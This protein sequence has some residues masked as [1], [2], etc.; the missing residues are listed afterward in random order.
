MRAKAVSR[1]AREERGQLEQRAAIGQGREQLARVVGAPLGGGDDLLQLRG[2]ARGR[3]VARRRCMGSHI[4]GSHIIQRPLQPGDPGRLVV[5][6][7]VAGAGLL[8]V[9]LGSAERV[10]RHLLAGH[11]PRHLG[12]GDEHVALPAHHADQIGERRG[13]RGRAHAEPARERE[14]R[15]LSLQR[16]GAPEDLAVGLDRVRALLDAHPVAVGERDHRQP[17]LTREI[18]Q[19]AELLRRRVADRAAQHRRVVRVDG[20]GAP[21]DRTEPADQPVAGM[22]IGGQRVALARVPVQRVLAEL[23]EAVRIAERRDPLAR[24]PLAQPLEPLLARPAAA[25]LG[26]RVALFDPRAQRL[27]ARRCLAVAHAPVLAALVA[28]TKSTTFCTLC[29]SLKLSTVALIPND[30]PTR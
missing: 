6:D 7:G 3:I 30:F 18:E 21:G 16:D 28:T 12:P 10:E 15:H 20:R 29:R 1:F 2:L 14:L 25:L 11:H 4:L 23:D 8:R 9:Q 22:E 17:A 27:P 5:E 13:V 19:A 24:G 26:A